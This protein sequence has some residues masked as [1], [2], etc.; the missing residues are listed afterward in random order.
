MQPR[1][2]V[3]EPVPLPPSLVC[4]KCPFFAVLHA[5]DAVAIIASRCCKNRLGR[6]YR[7]VFR[8]LF[9]LT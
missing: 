9:A 5:E 2:P 8:M 7:T 4:K 1:R 6:R 3:F